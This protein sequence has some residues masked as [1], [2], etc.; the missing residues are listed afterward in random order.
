M[1]IKPAILFIGNFLSKIQGT[2]GPTELMANRYIKD[3]RKIFRASSY[4]NKFIRLGDMVLKTLIYRYD[5]ISIDVYSSTALMFACITSKIAKLRHKKIIL[6]LH[7]G[8]LIDVYQQKKDEIV[9]L[10]KRASFIVT[11]SRFLKSYSDSLGFNVA[12]IP[13]TIDLGKFKRNDKNSGHRL[14]WVRAFTDNYNPDVAVKTF[15]E[16]L[17]KY[18]DATFTMVGPDKG[19]L[20]EIKQLIRELNIEDKVTITGRV[21]NNLLPKYYNSHNIYLNT[22]SYESFGVALVEAAA[23]GL[24]IVS[25]SVGEIPLMWHNGKDILL[26]DEIDPTSLANEVVKLLENKDFYNSIVEN[27][28]IK[29][30]GYSWESVSLKWDK[31]Y[32]AL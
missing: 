25:T 8:G 22:T 27:A 32:S 29:A 5:V 1:N 30:Q 16:V 26:S 10:F 19:N 24:P 18:P 4:K 17:Q 9:S 2:I 14:L 7:G 20:S 11:P 12:Y 15:Y 13:N 21:D 3:G 28:Y 23:C 6:V 31:I